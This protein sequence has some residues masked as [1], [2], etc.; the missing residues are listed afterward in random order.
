LVT[1]SG[2]DH[3][4]EMTYEVSVE[5][6]EPTIASASNRKLAEQKAAALMISYMTMKES[7]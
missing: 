6:Y 3:A 2:P 1:K 5:G 4:P 7:R